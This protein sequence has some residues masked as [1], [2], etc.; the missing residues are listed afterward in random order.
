MVMAGQHKATGPFANINDRIIVV[1]KQYK[2]KEL[3]I[4][5]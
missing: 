3:E 1:E 4:K 5:K 2:K